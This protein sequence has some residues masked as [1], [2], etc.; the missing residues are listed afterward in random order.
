[1]A[2]N[3]T[4]PVK[5]SFAGRLARFIAWVVLTPVV[6][7]LSIWAVLAINY[8]NLPEAWMRTA[9]AAV[10]ALVALVVLLTVR[11]RRKG[12]AVFAVLW[13]GVATWNYLIPA[14][15]N[16]EWQPDV[17]QLVTS[18]LKGDTLT[19]HTSATRR[20]AARPTT[21]SCGRRARTT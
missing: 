5:R 3:E 18:E 14:T 6:L 20:T 11:P 15:N 9:A 17:A 10:W 4:A 7:V 2:Q 8:S 1:M 16:A 12:L 21:T 19:I 13:L